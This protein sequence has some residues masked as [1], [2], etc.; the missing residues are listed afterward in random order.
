MAFLAMMI[1]GLAAFNQMSGQMQTYDSMVRSEFEMMANAVVID[2]MEII[3]ITTDYDD[4]EDW[5]DNES[6][7]SFTV[8]DFSVDFSIEIQVQY[9]DD[10]GDASESETD[11]KEVSIV[12]THE[13]FTVAL[14]NH[15]RIFSE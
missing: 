14:V 6:T 5:D 4:L 2:Q 7:R 9:I 13:K 3:D 1:A 10:D 11:Q 8:D 15:R 12:G